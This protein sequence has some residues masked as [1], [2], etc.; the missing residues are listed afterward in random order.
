MMKL[1]WIAISLGFAG[2][3]HCTGMCGSL[4]FYHFSSIHNHSY[5]IKFII[6]HLMRLIAYALLGMMFG[7]IGF[8]GTLTGAQQIISILSGILLIYIAATYFFPTALKILPDINFYSIINELFNFS[9]SSYYRYALSGFA[10][11]F[12]PCGFSFMAALFATTTYSMLHGMLFM[13]FFGLGTLPALIFVSLLSQQFQFKR[14]KYI[15]PTMALITGIFLIVRS[16]NLGIPYISPHYEIK[17]QN[18]TIECHK[19]TE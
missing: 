4:M 2:S 8:I 9:S 14:W 5:A 1:F 11:G 19:K 12:L 17:K 16:M 7:Q 15:M 6:Y 18:V 3:L 13:V 10:N